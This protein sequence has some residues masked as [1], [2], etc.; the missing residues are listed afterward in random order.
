MIV[1]SVIG[2]KVND[3]FEKNGPPRSWG[4]PNPRWRDVKS[5]KGCQEDG[6]VIIDSLIHCGSSPAQSTDQSMSTASLVN[7]IRN[8]SLFSYAQLTYLTQFKSSGNVFLEIHTP[9]KCPHLITA[10]HSK[11]P[12]PLPLPQYIEYV[13]PTL[14]VFPSCV[15]LIPSIQKNRQR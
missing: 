6:V 1:V 3:G 8:L 10:H 11:I 15:A 4:C 2:R 5:R 7:L 12:L 14:K 13:Q 9:C